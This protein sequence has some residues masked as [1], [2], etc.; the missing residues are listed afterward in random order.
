MSE[1][2]LHISSKTFCK[3]Y[4]LPKLNK[5]KK[6][7]EKCTILLTVFLRRNLEHGLETSTF[8]AFFAFYYPKNPQLPRSLHRTLP[9]PQALGNTIPG[10]I[11]CSAG[12]W[13][14]VVLA[15]VRSANSWNANSI[16]KSLWLPE[17]NMAAPEQPVCRL[18]VLCHNLN[19]QYKF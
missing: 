12:C 7:E 2:G 1:K 18:I 13:P 17:A 3:S 10:D 6:H 11:G 4:W 5:C 16:Q 9:P 8:A 15:R 14:G 19:F